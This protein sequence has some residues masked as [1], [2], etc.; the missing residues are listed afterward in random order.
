MINPGGSYLDQFR[1]QEPPQPPSYLDQFRIQEETE[2]EK[3]RRKARE[4]DELRQ[5]QLDAVIMGKNMQQRMLAA[6]L[7]AISSLA[8]NVRDMFEDPELAGYYAQ[9]GWEAIK[10]VGGGLVSDPVDTVKGLVTGVVWDSIVKPVLYN[11]IKSVASPN[12][13]TEE[14]QKLWDE[15]GAVG[16]GFLFGL[17]TANSIRKGISPLYKKILNNPT[18]QGID[19]IIERATIAEAKQ[20]GDDAIKMASTLNSFGRGLVEGGVGGFFGGAVFG[21]TAEERWQNAFAG[22]LFGS[23]I[24]GAIETGAGLFGKRKN[25][26]IADF[27][28]QLVTQ[29]ITEFLID[30][31]AKQ[32]IDFVKVFEQNSGDVVKSIFDLFTE[33]YH[34]YR[35]VAFN[36]PRTPFFKQIFDG[37]KVVGTDPNYYFYSMADIEAHTQISP[38]L[39][40]T[41]LVLSSISNDIAKNIGDSAVLQSLIDNAEKLIKEKLIPQ[42]QTHASQNNLNLNL[43]ELVKTNF[44]FGFGAKFYAEIPKFIVDENILV[45]LADVAPSQTLVTGIPSYINL[46]DARKFGYVF[47]NS[48]GTQNILFKY[49]ETSVDFVAKEIIIP[50]EDLV[51][52][53]EI[54]YGKKDYK[55]KLTIQQSGRLLTL[56]SDVLGQKPT[57]LPLFIGDNI[58]PEVVQLIQETVDRLGGDVTSAKHY[59]YIIEDSSIPTSKAI[60]NTFYLDKITYDPSYTFKP[61]LDVQYQLDTFGFLSEQSVSYK[62]KDYTIK[63]LY[64]KDGKKFADVIKSNDK[65]IKIKEK[66]PISE[67]SALDPLSKTEIIYRN[68]YKL[69]KGTVKEFMDTN[70]DIVTLINA[71]QTTIKEALD[72]IQQRQKGVAGAGEPLLILERYQRNDPTG[73]PTPSAAR[74]GTFYSI[75]DNPDLRSKSSYNVGETGGDKTGGGQ[76]ILAIAK[77][78]NPYIPPH[79]QMMLG[80][81]IA[82]QVISNLGTPAIHKKY[83]Q[84]FPIANRFAYLYFDEMG[85]PIYIDTNPF[86]Y[87]LEPNHIHAEIKKQQIKILKPEEAG[88]V[89]IILPD[90]T[91]KQEYTPVG[92]Q[93]RREFME[94]VGVPKSQIDAVLNHGALVGARDA[95][96]STLLKQNNYDAAIGG[97]EYF[98]VKADGSTSVKKEITLGARE[99]IPAIKFDLQKVV[100]NLMADEQSTFYKLV[101]QFDAANLENLNLIGEQLLTI[102]MYARNN[103]KGGI[104]V[105][106]IGKNRIVR[107]FSGKDA[108]DQLTEFANKHGLAGD[109]LASSIDLD[110]MPKLP[111]TNE[112]FWG[113]S[114]VKRNKWSHYID[115][116]RVQFNPMVNRY[117]LF[118]SLSNLFP[119]HNVLNTVF[120]PTQQATMLLHARMLPHTQTLANI[121]KKY[122]FKSHELTSL[123]ELIETMNPDEIINGLFANRK[124]TSAETNIADML[125]Q[126]TTSEQ[127]QNIYRYVRARKELID[128]WKATP[129]EFNVK[130]G[131]LNNIFG[132]DIVR[133]AEQYYDNVIAIHNKDLAAVYPI[134]RLADALQNQTLS[135]ADYIKANGLD[136]R[137][138]LAAEE[139]DKFFATLADEFQVPDAM[140]LNG[141]ISHIQK[142]GEGIPDNIAPIVSKETSG[143]PLKAGDMAQTL[144]EGFYASLTRTGAITEI[145]KDPFEVA[146]LYMSSGMRD[147]YFNTPLRNAI[148]EFE[149]LHKS[150]L[151]RRDF[152]AARSV[153]KIF[154]DYFRDLRGWM[155]PDE[156]LA[157]TVSQD[158]LSRL[159]LPK[160]EG[161]SW[162]NNWIKFSEFA[163]QGFKPVAGIRDGIVFYMNYA[164]RHGFARA[165]RMVALLNRAMREADELVEQ[166]KLPGL[167]LSYVETAAEKMLR[168]STNS[169]QFAAAYISHKINKIGDVGFKFSLQPQL[170]QLAHAAT[171]FEVSETV[172]KALTDFASNNISRQAMENI[173][174]LNLYEPSVITEFNRLVDAQD[175]SAATKHMAWASGYE[176]VG[177][178]GMANHPSFMSSKPGRIF[179]QF[180][181]WPLWQLQNLARM[182]AN[183]TP[184]QKA[185]VAAR[186]VGLIGAAYLA[187]EATGFRFSRGWSLSPDN[188][189][190]LGGP[191]VQ[192]A[193]F[194]AVAGGAGNPNLQGFAWEM[195][196]NFLDPT[197]PQV[198]NPIP[199]QAYYTLEGLQ[200]F[201]LGDP[202]HIA[203][204]R[205]L[206]LPID[207]Q[208][209]PSPASKR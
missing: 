38:E 50:P 142:Y 180:G 191:L 82:D 108:I 36:D 95:A 13:S 16:L 94:L 203:I 179:G 204:G 149:K 125:V 64:V 128:N 201:D 174:N 161:Q 154:H 12:L 169:K 65:G 199:M 197:R 133:L 113:A 190:F 135:R 127:R 7:R 69:R 1:I 57:K 45:G 4:Q 72:W 105:L 27:S 186:V 205:M 3:I 49:D 206:G 137:F 124:L 35:D 156:A 164:G 145:M 29:K 116:F 147:K 109:V 122:G 194:A 2:E 163:T 51:S 23:V 41:Q 209:Y 172:G 176:Q 126:S 178:F 30:L 146:Y 78:K 66:V 120:K 123:F 157:K 68:V 131:Q 59:G 181:T 11:P 130:L 60:I 10:G 175:Y 52:N 173:I 5:K 202:F 99:S 22:A 192:A 61:S 9:T 170:Y 196:K 96:A 165:N 185:A 193:Y 67:L 140:R 102:G 6:P 81:E 187:E 134:F 188:A 58:N 87:N 8:L 121:Q 91:F 100:S 104:D 148:K 37:N 129:D 136:A 93:L 152:G 79:N 111:N 84:M 40:E 114:E 19:D 43:H 207:T 55:D 195:T 151:D 15:T 160:V 26:Q 143:R 139:L 184:K 115:R 153:D 28:E 47:K 117:A 158:Y 166:G 39:K 167:G 44:N 75:I 106:D 141:Y 14:Q 171:L 92:M 42:L 101:T 32:K 103:G 119:E 25:L 31:P 48:D 21:E 73:M 182:T 132:D 168:E 80:A 112:G 83:T 34:A 76:R 90:G 159:G 33:K 88:I 138:K 86:F 198:W 20:L 77:P 118:S 54:A 144:P 183:G 189:L 74:G 63:K 150:L 200:R 97:G 98:D 208:K 107:S 70:D 53:L 155:H 62:G 89:K 71:Y 56:K 46:D 24:G 110:G 18:K 162:T 85:K 177:Y 17:G